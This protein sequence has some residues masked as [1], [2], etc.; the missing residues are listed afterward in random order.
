M[1][2]GDLVKNK[3]QFLLTRNSV[4]GGEIKCQQNVINIKPE[5]D[6][7]EYG[8]GYLILSGLDKKG[9]RRKE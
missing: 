2:P 3:L 6:R 7:E 1:D 5:A 4:T 8:G 9:L